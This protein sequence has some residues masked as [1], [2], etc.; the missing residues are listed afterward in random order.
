M[1]NKATKEVATK[2]TEENQWKKYEEVE[3]DDTIPMDTDIPKIST[4][5][6]NNHTQF[7]GLDLGH[8]T[9]HKPSKIPNLKKFKYEK[10]TGRIVQ[11]EVWNI[12]VTWG[13]SLS[14]LIETPVTI[15]FNY[16][17]VDHLF[18]LGSQLHVPWIYAPDGATKLK[19]CWFYKVVLAFNILL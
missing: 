18:Q 14:M 4:G 13:N 11:Q 2:A 12:P 3:N 6:P 1:E 8:H 10:F 7:N 17:L 5:G 15:F 16:D 19:I 9:P